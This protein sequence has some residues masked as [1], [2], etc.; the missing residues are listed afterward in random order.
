M[1]LEAKL[2]CPRRFEFWSAG[3]RNHILM[4]VVLFDQGQQHLPLVFLVAQ[5][6]PVEVDC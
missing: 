1:V 6:S 5:A 2:F 4:L 3:S